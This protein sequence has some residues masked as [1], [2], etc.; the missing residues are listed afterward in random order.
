M[1]GTIGTLYCSNNFTWATYLYPGQ[2]NTVDECSGTSDL[3]SE[4][5]HAM[6]SQAM[7]YLGRK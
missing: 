5:K 4:D 1:G 7:E 2:L 6:A 3:I